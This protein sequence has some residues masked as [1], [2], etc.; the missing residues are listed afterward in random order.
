MASKCVASVGPD[1]RVVQVSEKQ[2]IFKRVA[3]GGTLDVSVIQTPCP[4]FGILRIPDRV[5]CS[6]FDLK[7]SSS[8]RI[9]FEC[10]SKSDVASAAVGHCEREFE[11]A[12]FFERS[13]P[14][15]T[16]SLKK[17]VDDR[18]GAELLPFK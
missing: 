11:H 10:E 1:I 18:I 6:S 3:A 17:P 4:S 7:L 5:A 8:G 16:T 9:F 2:G 15:P 14:T 13:V 12:S